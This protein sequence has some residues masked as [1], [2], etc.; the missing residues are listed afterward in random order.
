MS[1]SARTTQRDH[2]GPGEYS[3]GP[4]LTPPDLQDARPD[5]GGL[6]RGK[7]PAIPDDT[8]MRGLADELADR[9]EWGRG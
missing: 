8:A 6:Y 4:G 7:S 9:A 1:A 5:E 2:D 3:W